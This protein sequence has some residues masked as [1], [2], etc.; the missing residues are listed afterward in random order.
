MVLSGEKSFWGN[1]SA[2]GEEVRRFINAELYV[3]CAGVCTVEPHL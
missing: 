2:W 3:I 1:E